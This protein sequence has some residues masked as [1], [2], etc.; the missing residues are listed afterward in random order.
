[1]RKDVHSLNY[2]HHIWPNIKPTPMN[3]HIPVDAG[4]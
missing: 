1:L 2:K 3:G 4:F